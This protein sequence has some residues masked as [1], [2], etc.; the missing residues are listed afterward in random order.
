L[1]R[2]VHRAL[3]PGGLFIS[4]DCQPARDPAVHRAQRQAWLAHLRRAYAPAR[5]A[6]ILEGWAGEDVYV[7]LDA[8]LG[9][10]RRSGFHVEVL[11]RRGAF[12]VLRAAR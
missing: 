2:R 3:R 9:L 10:L 4:V 5:A 11:W 7:P 8:E 1:Y 12:A 6:A